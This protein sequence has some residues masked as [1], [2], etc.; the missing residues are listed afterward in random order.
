MATIL[1]DQEAL[2]YLIKN[3]NAKYKVIKNTKNLDFSKIKEEAENQQIERER[4]GR[5]FVGNIAY[6]L[7]KGV[8]A[9]PRT[10]ITAIRGGNTE[11]VLDTEEA[12]RYKAN[13]LDFA[14]QSAANT[15][16]FFIP[17]GGALKAGQLAARAAAAG[18][19]SSFG[20][21]DL[22]KGLD[23][24]QLATGAVVGAAIPLAGRGLSSIGKTA[25]KIVKP[26]TTQELTDIIQDLAVE[27]RLLPATDKFGVAQLEGNF[28]KKSGSRLGL[29][30]LGVKS[31]GTGGKITP[32]FA[33]EAATDKAILDKVFNA[34]NLPKNENSIAT[35][36]NAIDGVRIVPNSGFKGVVNKELLDKATDTLIKKAPFAGLDRMTAGSKIRKVIGNLLGFEGDASNVIQELRIIDAGTLDKLAKQAFRVSNN[37]TKNAAAGFGVDAEAKYVLDAVDDV[38]RGILRKN[39]KGYDGISALWRTLYR[40]SSN[41]ASA[42]GIIEGV[43]QAGTLSIPR[44]VAKSTAGVVGDALEQTGQGFPA[45]QKQI[46]RI[47]G[48]RTLSRVMQQRPAPQFGEAATR[49][50]VVPNVQQFYDAIAPEQTTETVSEP[51]ENRLTFEQA[52]GMASRYTGGQIN[53]TTVSIAN[54]I[55]N[56]ETQKT[57]QKGNINSEA[58]NRIANITGQLVEDILPSGSGIGAR[59]EGEARRTAGNLGY[60]AKVA[61]YNKTVRALAIQL[62]R[63]LG[64]TGVL[65]D[66][67]IASY[68]GMLP[69]AN[70]TREEA[71]VILQ[72]LIDMANK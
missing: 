42:S 22:R 62:A 53:S 71:R 40:Q 2:D 31:T 16:S 63:A 61:A 65:S 46:A 54:N 24:G 58:I 8:T 51:V 27:D 13:P 32:V 6:D 39:V 5:G 43:S 50:P 11:G 10:A 1:R 29:E 18:A 70:S 28:V 64:D 15:G 9:L 23:V 34:T 72:N 3:P 12:R 52:L 57:A 30:K 26:K 45:I 37:L 33:N 21:Q 55:L 35:I 20:S 56:S 14:V 38:V 49:R 41:I 25:Q 7:F 47:P 4:A 44:L 48:N 59:L 60:D 69:S 66:Q 19:L 68:V 36:Y 67:D 17:L